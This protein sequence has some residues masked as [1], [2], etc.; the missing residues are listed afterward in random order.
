M[1]FETALR[2]TEILLGLALVQH[3][4]EHL[5]IRD[6][7]RVL[8]AVRAA[9]AALLASGIA[10]PIAAPVVLALSL[11]VL[12]RYDG[13]FNGGA[14]RM[15]L[16][17]QVCVTGAHLAPTAQWREVALGYLAIQLVLSYAISGWVKVVNRDW[18]SG[19]ALRDVFAFSAYPASEDLRGL[20]AHPRLLF[21][22]SWAVILFELAFPVAV[23]SQTLLLAALA[24]AATF[25]LAN[26]ILFG[27]N[28]FVWAWI[29][30]YPSI[31]WLH[32]R[33]IG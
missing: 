14:D 6:G 17:A 33:V 29:A 11:A 24:L 8:H 3:S 26:A 30:A 13:P 20:S 22:A 15:T 10:G 5:A 28:R 12:A 1:T 31:I 7:A 4:L 18:R 23:M 16:L 27:L 2:L 9:A 19:H 32:D 25:H 21:T